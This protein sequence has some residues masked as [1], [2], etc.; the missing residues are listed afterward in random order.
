[1]ETCTIG[2]QPA[3]TAASSTFWAP[4]KLVPDTSSSAVGSMLTTAAAW[5][6]A[7]QPSTAASTAAAS[8]MSPCTVSTFETST[9]TRAVTVSS[10]AG[11][12]TSALTLWPASWRALAAWDPTKP[13]APVTRT[14]TGYPPPA[15][16]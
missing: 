12:R 15:R 13:V 2:S 9:P 1:M 5:T 8:R 7:S 10:L 6:T 4:A 14:L 11:V 16:G 3:P